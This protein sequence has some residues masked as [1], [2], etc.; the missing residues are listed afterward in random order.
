MTTRLRTGTGS[1][2]TRQSWSAEHEK[3]ARP[4]VVERSMPPRT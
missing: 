4:R 1:G 3:N 2:T